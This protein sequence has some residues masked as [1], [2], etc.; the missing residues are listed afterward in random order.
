[1]TEMRADDA[2]A[3]LPK[4]GS[5]SGRPLRSVPIHR[6]PGQFAELL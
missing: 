6:R 4:A 2:T 5:G 3:V 1:M